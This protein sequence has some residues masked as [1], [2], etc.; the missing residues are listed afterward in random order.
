MKIGDVVI[1]HNRDLIVVEIDG[2]IITAAAIVDGKIIYK[3]TD[4]RDKFNEG[5]IKK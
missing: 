2:D 4:N 1:Y 3:I 5:G